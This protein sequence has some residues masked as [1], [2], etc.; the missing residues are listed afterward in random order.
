MIKNLVN[1]FRG[2]TANACFCTLAV[3][4][5][6]RHRA[7]QLIAGAPNVPWIV[8]T[9][10]PDDFAG[11]PVQAIR[12]A[13]T[14][15]M[16]VDF[17]TTLPPTG[18]RLGWPAY[19]DKRF[20][21]QAVLKEFETAVF[22]DADSRFKSAPRFST[23]PRGIA[24]VK[25]LRVSIAEHLTRYG[26]ARRPAF[27]QLALHLFGD[28][29]AL[30]SARWCSE[31]LFTVTK[32]GGREEKFLEAWAIAAEF[33]KS[34]EVFTGEGGVIGLAAK[35]AGWKVDYNGLNRLAAATVHEGHGPKSF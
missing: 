31:A 11:F 26:P 2:R 17:L 12:H 27:E 35:Y 34:R 19:H 25:E 32:D 9:D 15:P 8:L 5:P 10:E 33:L 24:V 14:G 29:K 23:F 30:E 6:Y 16:A 7:Q 20:V 21:L 22:V 1:L 3:H 28:V 18:D 4:A 13:P